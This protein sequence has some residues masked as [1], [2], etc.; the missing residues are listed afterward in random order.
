MQ[1]EKNKQIEEMAKVIKDTWLVDLEGNTYGVCEF[2][3]EVDIKSIAREL[4]KQNYRK[5]PKDSVV[6]SRE[7]YKI[8]YNDERASYYRAENLAIENDLL[9]RKLI[10]TRKETA[11]KILKIIKDEYGYIGDLE[12]IIAKQFGVEIK[13]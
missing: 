5:L 4:R 10:D 12:R 11:E 9:N 8:I 3:D 6:L 13:A 7:E 2:L 1:E